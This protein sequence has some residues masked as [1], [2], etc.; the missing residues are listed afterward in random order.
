MLENFFAVVF[1]FVIIYKVA[2]HTDKF[3]V[4]SSRSWQTSV[5][6]A[7]YFKRYFESLITK[8]KK[9]EKMELKENVHFPQTFGF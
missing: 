6:T 1:S 2:Y 9:E 3:L 7:K 5:V 4:L 8:K